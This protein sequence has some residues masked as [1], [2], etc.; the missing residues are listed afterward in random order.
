MLKAGKV[1]ALDTTQNLL[2]SFAGLTVRV[3]ASALPEG[4]QKCVQ[5]R[6]GAM[7]LLS[8]SGYADLERLLAEFRERGIAIA[9]LSLQEADLEQ[10]FLRIM[11]RAA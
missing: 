3:T 4:W 7:Y 6:E 8:L 1:V 2:S 10:V 5:R 11:K 9:E